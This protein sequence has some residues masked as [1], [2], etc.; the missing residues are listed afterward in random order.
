MLKNLID[1]HNKKITA[2]INNKQQ[3]NSKHNEKNS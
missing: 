3:K 1:K 2:Y